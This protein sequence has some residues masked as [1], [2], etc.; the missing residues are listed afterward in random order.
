MPRRLWVVIALSAY[1]LTLTGCQY[2]PFGQTHS[3]KSDLDELD[4][5]QAGTDDSAA[6]E[7]T[8]VPASEF[9]LKLER[10]RRF[11]L[12]KTVEQHITQSQ[13]TGTVVGRSKLELMLSLTVEEV[14]G[15]DR[16][17]GVRYHRVRFAQHLDGQM[18]EYNSETPGAVVPAEA[19]AYAG[20]KDNGFSFWL[21]PAN[22]VLDLVGFDDFLQRCVRNVPTEQKPAVMQ[23]LQAMRSEDG[24]ANFVDD[25]IGLLPHQ[26]DAKPPQ[27]SLQLGSTWDLVPRS[28]ARGS[29]AAS[30]SITR[31]RLTRLDPKSAEIALAGS[32]G[33]SS[34]VDELRR[35][36]LQVRGGQCSG[37]CT[38]DRETG[39]PTH[40]RIERDL[41]MTAELADGSQINQHKHVVTTIV[42]FL[43]QGATRPT[44]S[45]SDADGSQ[46]QTGARR[47]LPVHQ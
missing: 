35:V 23:Q 37:N 18:V 27:T 22:Q 32:I 4:E 15:D 43:E 46:Q 41:D 30:P 1:G 42:A 31:C 24:L 44:A 36:R 40:S 34:Y 7:E 6:P 47:A 9:A 45:L 20:L 39:M 21:G 16:R 10:G 29:T 14:R 38:V 26:A 33:P 17:L 5:F 13:A 19:L 12:V 8:A 25:S 3:A 28:G 2:L 11:P